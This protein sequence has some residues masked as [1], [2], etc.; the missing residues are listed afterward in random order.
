MIA[1]VIVSQSLFNSKN[2]TTTNIYFISQ[3]IRNK[4][5]S[6][7]IVTQ[8]RPDFVNREKFTDQIFLFYISI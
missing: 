1:V 7:I 5:K 6:K 8:I 3:S 2:F 4:S